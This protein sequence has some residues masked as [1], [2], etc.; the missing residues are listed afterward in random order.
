MNH[1]MDLGIKSIF[2]HLVA[3]NNW[4]LVADNR[5]LVA[6]LAVLEVSYWVPLNLPTG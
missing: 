1:L 5:H 2:R 4:H 3:D 6:E